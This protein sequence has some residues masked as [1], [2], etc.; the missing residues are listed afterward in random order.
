MSVKILVLS[1]HVMY[2]QFKYADDQ[3][4]IVKSVDASLKVFAAV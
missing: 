2:W 1:K 3:I 4:L